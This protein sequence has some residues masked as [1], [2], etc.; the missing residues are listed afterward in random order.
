MLEKERL[1]L[2]VVGASY[3]DAF[4]GTVPQER[5]DE[6]TRRM[7]TQFIRDYEKL[8]PTYGEM[9]EFGKMP[10]QWRWDCPLGQNLLGNRFPLRLPN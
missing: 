3:D 5:L 10:W 1:N 6:D 2:I 9:R 7:L 4:S 8:D